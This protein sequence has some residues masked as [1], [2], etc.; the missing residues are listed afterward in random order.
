MKYLWLFILLLTIPARA[1]TIE[2]LPCENSF[3]TCVETLTAQAVENSQSIKLLDDTIKLAKRRGWTSYID[4]SALNPVNSV[5]AVNPKR[6]WR[7]R[8]AKAENRN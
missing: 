7:R 3:E 4:V 2:V 5:F 6:A 8:A 1:Q